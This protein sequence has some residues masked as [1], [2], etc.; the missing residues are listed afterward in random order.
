MPAAEVKE[1]AGPRRAS[2]LFGLACQGQGCG[3]P[4][5]DRSDGPA[6]PRRAPSAKFSCFFPT[7][8][9]LGGSNRLSDGGLK[10]YR[11]SNIELFKLVGSVFS[12]K[13]C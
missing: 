3:V 13:I 4:G 2:Q 7:I 8:D 12:L 5:S 9:E 6:A 11:Q 1:L 10:G